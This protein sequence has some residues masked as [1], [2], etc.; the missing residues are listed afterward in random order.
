MPPRSVAR[1]CIYLSLCAVSSV[2]QA[3][4]IT[5]SWEGTVIPVAAGDDPWSLGAAPLDFWVSVSVDASAADLDTLNQDIAVFD[6]ADVHFT[7]EGMPIAPVSLGTL[8]F[9]DGEAVPDDRI[10]YGG[11]FEKDGIPIE[12]G[13]SASLD[14]E[15]FGFTRLAASPPRFGT[16]FNAERI[17]R[18]SGPYQTLVEIGTVVNAAP[19]PSATTI[20]CFV[21]FILG[22]LSP[23]CRLPAV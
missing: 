1:A 23:R 20:L 14:S 4:Q 6:A 13:F 22:N 19:E 16:A 2:L 10:D 8:I 18:V 7:I 9:E 3:G 11:R 17:G 21:S 12:V 5:Y 15:V